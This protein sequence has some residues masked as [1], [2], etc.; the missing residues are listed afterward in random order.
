MKVFK[1]RRHRNELGGVLLAIALLSFLSYTYLGGYISYFL[2]PQNLRTIVKG[3]G[4]FGPAAIVILQFIQV[5]IV[6]VPPVV[7]IVSGYAFGPL[8]GTLY[9]LIGAFIGSLAIIYLSRTYGRRFVSFFV[10]EEMMTKFDRFTQSS[11]IFPYV[12]LFTVPGFHDDALCFIAGLT[13]IDIR[14]L[15]AVATLGRIPGILALTLVGD[16]I[17]TARYM[18][19]ALI[20]GVLIAFSALSVEF[21][22]EAIEIARQ[23]EEKG[24]SALYHL[25]A[26]RER[27]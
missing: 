23:L 13:R 24:L 16:S 6:P 20:S 19:M 3:F 5:M 4:V 10:R 27:L 9:S 18:L 7:P 14:K 11:G 2:Q 8:K 17:A 15:V 21:E 26:L 25:E 12:V 1:S 22:D